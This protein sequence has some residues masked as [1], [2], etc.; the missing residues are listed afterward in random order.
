MSDGEKRTCVRASE[1]SQPPFDP[2]LP[3]AAA[4]AADLRPGQ[5]RHR[6][7]QHSL[8]DRTCACAH[9]II[10]DPRLSDVLPAVTCDMFFNFSDGP[11]S[12]G[13]TDD[14]VEEM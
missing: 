2:S 5:G 3:A 8:R 9:R 11:E 1:G 7:K 10:L 4:A 14:C 12:R 13:A 6:I